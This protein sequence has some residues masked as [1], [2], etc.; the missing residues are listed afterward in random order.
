MGHSIYGSS[1]NCISNHVWAAILDITL[2]SVHLDHTLLSVLLS[3][4][5]RYGAKRSLTCGMVLKPMTNK[6]NPIRLRVVVLRNAKS[7]LS[8][9]IRFSE[10]FHSWSLSLLLAPEL[11]LIKLH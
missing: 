1:S 7:N 6:T 4:N 11:Q 8:A 9:L 3:P 10:A 5:S 2:Y